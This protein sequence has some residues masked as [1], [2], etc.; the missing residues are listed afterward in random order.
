MVVLNAPLLAANNPF[1]VNLS[2]RDGGGAA[3]AASSAIAH[4]WFFATLVLKTGTNDPSLGRLWQLLLYHL[5]QYPPS[6]QDMPQHTAE[7]QLIATFVFV[8][9]LN[10]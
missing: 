3:S 8:R 7:Q 5:V 10:Q 4:Q 2:L 9:L 6:Q 1:Q